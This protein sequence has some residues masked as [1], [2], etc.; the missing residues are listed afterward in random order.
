MKVK[1]SILATL[2]LF[3]LIIMNSSFL[4][5]QEKD[6]LLTGEVKGVI[7]DTAYRFKLKSATV[8]VYVKKDS[9]LIQYQLSNTIGAF[10]FSKLPLDVPLYLVASYVGYED[11]TVGFT[12]PRSGPKTDLKTVALRRQRK[13]CFR[14]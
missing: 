13:S 4:L 2:F 14:K 7:A 9:S 1:K 10:H 11:G 6:T 12:I 5:A 3:T 8:A